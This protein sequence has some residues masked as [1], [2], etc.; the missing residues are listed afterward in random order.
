MEKT[1]PENCDHSF[2]LPCWLLRLCFFHRLRFVSVGVQ[3][4]SDRYRLDIE[5][6]SPSMFGYSASASAQLPSPAFGFCWCADA[7]RLIVRKPIYDTAASEMVYYLPPRGLSPVGSRV[8]GTS[9]THQRFVPVLSP[10][11]WTNALLT[12][13]YISI[14]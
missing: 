13:R 8:D 4:L 2:S 6:T 9:A 7:F 3:T 11:L 10:T 1:S 5:T 14:A 12:Y